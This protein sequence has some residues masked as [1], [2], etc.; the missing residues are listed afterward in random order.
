MTFIQHILQYSKATDVFIKTVKTP[1]TKGAEVGDFSLLALFNLESICT[2][3]PIYIIK[4]I[5]ELNIGIVVI[6][7]HFE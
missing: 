5:L 3:K 1:N 6:L 4:P 2:L 7:A